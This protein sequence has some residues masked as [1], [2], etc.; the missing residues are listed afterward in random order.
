[1]KT[2]E[3]LLEELEKKAREIAMLEKKFKQFLFV[4]IPLFCVFLLCCVI[5]SLYPSISY[6]GMFLGISGAILCCLL[7]LSGMI[8]PFG[9]ISE[10]K[11]KKYFKA[12]LE[13]KIKAAEEELVLVT[14]RKPKLEEELKLLKEI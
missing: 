14:N 5:V 13:Q 3:S 9:K 8:L 2:K 11:V 1:M 4:A 6:N 7:F 12:A 10:D